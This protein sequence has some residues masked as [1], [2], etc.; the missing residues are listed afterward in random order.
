[1]KTIATVNQLNDERR[2]GRR[3]LAKMCLLSACLL[4][5]WMAANQAAKIYPGEN[6]PAANAVANPAP[7]D[8]AHSAEYRAA[9]L[10]YTAQNGMRDF[11]F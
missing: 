11:P 3:D 6:L 2:P 7:Y 4:L 8:L 10:S 5:G 9:A 1:M